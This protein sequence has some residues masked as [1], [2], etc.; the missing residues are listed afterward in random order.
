MSTEK[1]REVVIAIAARDRGTDDWT[2]ND[3][4]DN[5]PAHP[6]Y[7]RIKEVVGFVEQGIQHARQGERE[8]LKRFIGFID[9]YQGNA[10]GQE[11][12]SEREVDS[13]RRHIINDFLEQEESK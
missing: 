6:W 13:Y 5:H 7:P 1:D 10:G 11:F 4:L 9:E 3:I 2:A 12:W 8:R